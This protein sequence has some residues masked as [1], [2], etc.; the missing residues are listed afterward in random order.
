VGYYRAGF[1]VVGVDLKPQ[2]RYP[3]PF[4]QADALK[5]PFDLN[6]FDVIHA[7]PPCQGYSRSRFIGNISRKT[8][9]E[10]PL[11]IGDVRTLLKDCKGITV[12]ENVEQSPLMFPVLL[13]GA[14]FGLGVGGFDLPRHRLFECSVLLWTPP[15]CHRRGKTIG[16]YGN[17]T[18]LFHRHKFGRNLSDK[19]KKEA[20]QIDWMTRQQLSQAIPP[21][22]TEYIGKQLMRL[23]TQT[24]GENHVP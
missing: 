8:P 7:S 16:V 1:D 13:C 24:K 15:C 20:M 23:I 10:T 17:G 14:C 5:P 2:K 3:F 12:I 4:V 19:H 6:Q 21:A 9:M 22:Y 18:N 11:L